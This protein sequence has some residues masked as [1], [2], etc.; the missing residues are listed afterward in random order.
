MLVVCTIS[1]RLRDTGVLDVLDPEHVSADKGY[2][3]SGCDAPYKNNVVRGG[4]RTG[5]YGLTMAS[6]KFAMWRNESSRI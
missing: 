3:G 5:R 6:A 1:R 2:V 4:W